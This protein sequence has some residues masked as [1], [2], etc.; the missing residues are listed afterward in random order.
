MN[1]RSRV[2]ATA[3]DHGLAHIVWRTASGILG[4]RAVC[5]VD[6]TTWVHGDH[7]LPRCG[8]CKEEAGKCGQDT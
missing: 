3:P 2:W 7:G 4:Y 6:A 1:D 8:V 5:L